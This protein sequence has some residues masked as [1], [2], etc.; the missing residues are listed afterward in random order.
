MVKTNSYFIESIILLSLLST[1][2]HQ[3]SRIR[4][5]AAATKIISVSQE[6]ALT[7]RKIEE[8]KLNMFKLVSSN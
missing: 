5:H 7:I 6:Y 1:F 2:S 4:A 8:V 3:N